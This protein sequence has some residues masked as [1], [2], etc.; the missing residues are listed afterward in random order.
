RLQGHHSPAGGD[1]RPDLRRDLERRERVVFGHRYILS[2]S[3]GRSRTG[4]GA[5]LRTVWGNPWRFESSRP[6]EYDC[7]PP[8][9]IKGWA[10]SQ[11]GHT[12]RDFAR[13]IDYSR[14]PGGGVEPHLRRDVRVDRERR[15]YV[16]MA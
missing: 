10:W 7:G 5:R 6:H 4:T 16:L 8:S 12:R 3:R 1:G 15:L 2:G 13:A 9:P 11:N 14:Q